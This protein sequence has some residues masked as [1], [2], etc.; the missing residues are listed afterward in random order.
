MNRNAKELR[1]HTSE[2]GSLDWFKLRALNSIKRI[3]SRNGHTV[4]D[5][6]D[7]A[8][9]WGPGAAEVYAGVQTRSSYGEQVTDPETKFIAKISSELVKKLPNKLIYVDLGPGTAEKEKSVLEEMRK[10]GKD[11][12][13]VP[14]DINKNML[15]AASERYSQLGIKSIPIQ[16]PFE[17]LNLENNLR[18]QVKD[19]DERAVFVSLGLTFINYQPNNCLKMLKRIMGNNG[20]A[21]ITSELRSGVDI[22]KIKEAYLSSEAQELIKLKLSLLRIEDRDI[23]KVIATNDVFIKYVL[24]SVPESLKVKGVKQDDEILTVRTYRHL[25]TKLHKLI[26]SK[27]K[28][29]FF[30]DDSEQNKFAAVLLN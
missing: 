25:L 24:G 30:L 13:Y 17:E 14:V 2:M 5:F 7:S 10:Q 26:D 9:L 12:I 23:K 4:W 29:E 16:S 3:G 1:A 21:F 11:I 28:A 6:S 18:G 20:Y 22:E 15:V 8:C 19:I 27:F